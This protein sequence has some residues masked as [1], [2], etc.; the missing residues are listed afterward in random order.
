MMGE[1]YDPS[2]QRTFFARSAWQLLLLLGE[3]VNFMLKNS[4]FFR[5]YTHFGD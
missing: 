5:R 1:A 2:I 4:T 3:E